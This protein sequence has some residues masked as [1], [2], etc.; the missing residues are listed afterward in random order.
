MKKTKIAMI[1]TAAMLLLAGCGD[2]E[3]VIS[4]DESRP[5]SGSEKQDSE[6]NT[7]AKGYTFSYQGVTIGMDVSVAPVLE[8]LGEPVE[9]F[10]AESCAF[11]GMNKI[12]T[13]NSFV[14]ETYPDQ[15][16]DLI[17]RVILKDDSIATPE[18]IA[19]GDSRTKVEEVYGADGAT[20]GNS[21]V[22]SKEGMKLSFIFN[23]SD[24][25]V[26]SIEY[27]STALE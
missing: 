25:S 20:E 18:G 14:V 1:V 23:A 13:Y 11:E 3:R 9:Y 19:I 4:G 7:A 2:S 27:M 8:K 15:E 6:A 16:K 22:Y 5:S 10:E 26:I 17:S 21:V 12:Y 24:D